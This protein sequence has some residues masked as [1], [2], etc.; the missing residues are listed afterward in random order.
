M[1]RIDQRRISGTHRNDDWVFLLQEDKMDIQRTKRDVSR[2]AGKGAVVPKGVRHRLKSDKGVVVL[3]F[4][5]Q[6]T[7]REGD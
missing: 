7:R 3:D 6:T 1:V 2:E 4:E 5:V